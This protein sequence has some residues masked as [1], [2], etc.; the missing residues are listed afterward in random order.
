MLSAITLDVIDTF[1]DG[2]PILGAIRLSQ[3]YCYI[4]LSCYTEKSL[5]VLVI[6][7]SAKC[8]TDTLKGRKVN[9]RSTSLPLIYVLRRDT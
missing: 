9:A 3:I 6:A 8:T 7:C 2:Y 5:N 1:T 4:Y